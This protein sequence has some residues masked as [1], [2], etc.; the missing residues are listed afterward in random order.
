MFL[1]RVRPQ[2]IEELAAYEYLAEAPTLN[3]PNI[4]PR[5]GKEF[6]PQAALF[7]SVPNEMSAAYN[8]H[9]RRHVAFHALGREGKI[10]MRTAATRT[11]PWSAPAV[12]YEPL[13]LGKDDLIYAA[14]EHPELAR[15]GG[16]QAYVTFVNSATYVPEMIEVT[17]S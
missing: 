1:A 17:F 13:R 7:D 9:L 10:V 12:I 5:W 8:P 16:R 11:G 3:R 14:K 6:S 2:Q 15:D 4:E